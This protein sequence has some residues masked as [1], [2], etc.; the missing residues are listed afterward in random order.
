MNNIVK[1]FEATY[2]NKDACETIAQLG[3]VAFDAIINSP[4]SDKIPIVSFLKNL[5]K[6]TKNIQLQRL[7]KKVH[8]FIFATQDTTLVERRNFINEYTIKNK[9]NGCEALLAIIDK[10]DNINKVDILANLIKAKIREDI[11]IEN[12]IRLCTIIDRI[13]FSDFNELSKYAVDYYE[14]G[15]TDVLLSAGVIFNTSIDA[16]EGNKYRLNSLGKSLLKYGLL[17]NIHVEKKNSTTI[18]GMTWE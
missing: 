5:Y 14:D 11:T 16:N 15:S 12:F 3:D 13:P 4:I 8:K 10:Y 2:L 7:I 6:T 9:E 1:S 18:A 17:N